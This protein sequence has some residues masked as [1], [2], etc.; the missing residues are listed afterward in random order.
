MVRT[1]MLCA[2]AAASLLA[3]GYSGMGRQTVPGQTIPLHVKTG[4]WQS[5]QKVKVSGGLGLPPEMAAKMTPEQRERYEA[6][7]GARNHAY[8]TTSKGCLTQ[9]DL[10][11]DLYAKLNRNG[12]MQ[13]QGNIV[14]SSASELELNEHCIG[15]GKQ[16]GVEMTMHMTIHA[17]DSEHATGAGQGTA[18]M[19]GKTMHSQ[20]QVDS[21]WLG[22]SCPAD[23]QP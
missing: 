4:L 17:T 23:L 20:V 16:E 8:E 11:Q 22:A 2:I 21:V 13:C 7:M 5:T 9:E 12:D 6:A 15:Q 1:L 19:G 14:R 18:T 3:T 10:S